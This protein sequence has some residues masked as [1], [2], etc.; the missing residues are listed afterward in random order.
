VMIV[1]LR[2]RGV[3]AGGETMVD[4]QQSRWFLGPELVVRCLLDV[5][6]VSGESWNRANVRSNHHKGVMS[7]RMERMKGGKN[8]IVGDG[9]GVRNGYSD[10]FTAASLWP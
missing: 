6:G 9:D 3:G 2:S 7:L 8:L 4:L 5:A 1:A 10:P